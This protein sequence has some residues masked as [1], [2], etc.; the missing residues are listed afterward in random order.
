MNEDDV[1]ADEDLEAQNDLNLSVNQTDDLLNIVKT[2]LHENLC[3]Y[4][5][6]QDPNTLLASL[7]DSR[8]KILDNIPAQ[9]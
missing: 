5:N 1:F 9:V 8:T 2:K 3:R 6:F 7:L 4:W